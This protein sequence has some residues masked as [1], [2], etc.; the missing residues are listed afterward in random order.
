MSQDHVSPEPILRAM[1]GFMASQQ[2]F[3]A[4]AIG[5]FEA[6]AEGPA[7]LGEL[8]QR[9]GTPT[10]STGIVADAMVALGLLEREDGRYGNGE[11]ASV[12]LAG[13]TPADLRPLLRFAHQL[14]YPRMAYLEEAVRRGGAAAP[15]YESKDQPLYS[16]AIQAVTMGDAQ[17]LARSYDFSGHRR[18]LDLGGGLG[19]FLVPV[20]TAHPHLQATLFELPDVAELARQRLSRSQ[21][22]NRVAIQAGNFF[23]DAIPA[24]HDVILMAHILHN[25]PPARCRELLARVGEAVSERTRLLALDYWMNPAR[26]EPA[27][28][29]LLAG[30]LHV[31]S[32]GQMY[33]AREGRAWLAETGWEEIEHRRFGEQPA[34]LLVAARG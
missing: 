26:T 25:F 33:S 15:P 6:L 28:G 31:D 14:E 1:G 21:V 2:L 19:T 27:F 13:Q 10:R 23:A 18:L 16:Q 24:G 34:S 20:L 9:T 17:A 11:A 3:T 8:A 5:L 30:M 12:F 4:Q 22:G 32:G 7:D 29:A